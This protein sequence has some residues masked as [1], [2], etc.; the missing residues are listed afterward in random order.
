MKFTTKSDNPVTADFSDEAVILSCT[1][2][3]HNSDLKKSVITDKMVLTHDELE[4]IF[5]AYNK[6]KGETK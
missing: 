5:N 3:T 1:Y 2:E 4:Q 6:F